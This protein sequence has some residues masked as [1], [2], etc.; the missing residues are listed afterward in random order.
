MASPSSSAQEARQA[1][2]RRLRE[3]RIDAGLTA[4]DL[5]RLMGRHS[6]KVSRV[7][8]GRVAPLAAD[9][10]AWCEHCGAADQADDL[11]AA[12]RAVEEMWVEWRRVE[13]TG[14]RRAQ[15]T[16]LPLYERTRRF[17][18]YSPSL[19]PGVVQTAAYTEAVLRAVARRRHIPDDIAE[20]VA[21]R[22]ERQRLLREGE[23]RFALLVEESALRAGFGG[24]EVMAAQ[25][26]HLLTVAA[27]PSVSL[28]VVPFG[29]ER[30]AAWPVEA[31]YMFDDD[32]VGVELVSGHLTV[33]RPSEV[34]MYAQVFA[35]L[36]EVA[37]YGAAARSL[38]TAAIDALGE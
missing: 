34:A 35:E 6:S 31:F 22:M 9:L 17:R 30:D 38:I 29:S 21:A 5:A 11:V 27:L 16:R 36:A 33:T 3:L 8:N 19:V 28:G 14:L 4:R 23:R 26:G 24:A 18:F 13:R 25:L 1:L 37:V 15:E 12:L 10:R 32:Q 20:A 2:G 7:E